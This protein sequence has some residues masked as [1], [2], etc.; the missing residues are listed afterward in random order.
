MQ[1]IETVHASTEAVTTE[2]GTG[3]ATEPGLLASMGINP[4]GLATQFLNFAVVVAIL[5]FLILKPLTKKMAERQKLIDESLENTKK[6]QDTLQRSEQ[7]YQERIDQAKVEGNKIVEKATS[8]AEAVG[9]ELKVKAREEIEALVATGKKN[10][11]T[12]KQEMLTEVKKEAVQMTFAALE[13]VL[14][15]K[16]TEHMDKSFTEDMLAE[17][18]KYEQS[19]R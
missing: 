9:Q 7:K 14:S 3:A 11:E 16:V 19:K 13:K 17:L 18:E 10:L 12:Q 6:I 5:W 2:Q 8:E 15:A 1:F 4:T